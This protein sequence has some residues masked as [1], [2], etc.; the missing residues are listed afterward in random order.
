MVWYLLVFRLQLNL[1]LRSCLG[2]SALFL[3]LILS[4]GGCTTSLHGSFVTSTYEGA[5]DAEESSERLGPVQ[6]ESCQTAFLYF[7]PLGEAPSTN[8]AV[9]DAKQQIEGTAF[10]ADLAIDD[11]R[12][13]QFGYLVSCIRVDAVAFGSA[14]S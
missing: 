9:E 10:L 2:R 7:F 12:N 14:N 4:L 1:L 3:I 6:G 8:A 5:G 11:H 13:W